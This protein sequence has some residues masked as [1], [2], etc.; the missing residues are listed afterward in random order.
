L[1]LDQI[2]GIEHPIVLAPMFLI[3]DTNMVKSALDSGITAAI[4]ALNYRTPKELEK[5]IEDLKEYSSKPFGINLIVNKS[6]I[7]LKNQFQVCL[8]HKV[9]YIITALGSPKKIIDKC[10]ARGIKVFCD[11]AN[12]HHARKAAILGADAVIALNNR[13]GGHLG[14]LSAEEFIPQLINEIDIPVISAGGVGNF[15]QYQKIMD[16]GAVGCSVGSIFIAS[17]E[18]PV[19]KEYKD[20]IVSYGEKDI[21]ITRKLSG[22]PCTVINTE[23]IRNQAQKTNLLEYLF[24][25]NKMLRKYIRFIISKK[26]MNALKKS[27]FKVTYDKVWC[28]GVSIEEVNEVLTIPQ[29]VDKL[30]N[31]DYAASRA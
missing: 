14:S 17:H 31:P 30:V 25:R 26:G 16:L 28:A 21:I 23:F 6:N 10:K 5:A 27:A 7:Y 29:I 4:P 9:D 8:D 18:S 22:S 15:N 3:S 1:K 19:T 20:A 11:V 24:K 12:I 13:A 2:L